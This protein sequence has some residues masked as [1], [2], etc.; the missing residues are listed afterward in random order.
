MLN[1]IA[2]GWTFSWIYTFYSGYPVGKPDALFSC[3]DYRV[4]E[5]NSDHW[6]NN[7]RSCY[8][9]R[10]PYTLRTV[11]ARFPNLR[12]TTQRQLH[13]AFEKTFQ[14]TERFKTL[15]RGESFNVANTVIYPGPDTN[16]QSP[17][18][19]MLPLQQNNFPRLVQL[20]AKF[21]F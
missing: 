13:F 1:N 12:N 7:D 14:L 18:F 9:Q 4:K 17:R 10:P 11:E 8:A 6:L 20:A 21:I 2:G 19:G 15:I 3:S 5:Q 16:W